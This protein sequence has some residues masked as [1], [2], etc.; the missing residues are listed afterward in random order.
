MIAFNLLLSGEALGDPP[1]LQ[2]DDGPSKGEVQSAEI[3]PVRNEQPMRPDYS[4]PYCY[5]GA[6]QDNADLCAQ[7]RAALA[8]EKAVHQAE[9]SNFVGLASAALSF[10]S[11]VLVLFAL[12]TARQANRISMHLGQAQVRAYVGMSDYDINYEIR[13]SG[14]EVEINHCTIVLNWKNS[15]NSPALNF[16]TKIDYVFIDRD[17]TGSPIES[18]GSYELNSIVYENILSGESLNDKIEIGIFNY[19][20][21]RMRGC[22]LLLRTYIIYEDVFG[23]VFEVESCD[24]IEFTD[25]P[26][27]NITEGATWSQKY[28]HHNSYKEHNKKR[29]FL[30]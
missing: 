18:F 27:E 1:H 7:W 15:G 19:E 6:S 24:S 12:R 29:D 21:W 14:E 11:F 16:R 28:P 13:K 8:A 17:H 20:K 25:L 3:G 23:T 9:I 22:I 26:G 10:L 2:S 4:G 30:N 5:Q